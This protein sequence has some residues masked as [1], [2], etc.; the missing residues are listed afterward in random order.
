MKKILALILLLGLVGMSQAR[1]PEPGDFVRVSGAMTS[2]TFSYEGV[3]TDI[4]DGLICLNCSLLG[5][6]THSVD[7]EYPFDV[8]IGTGTIISLVWLE[9]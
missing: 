4:K 2:A 6:G 8:C 7:R 5:S 3:I 9:G 1:F